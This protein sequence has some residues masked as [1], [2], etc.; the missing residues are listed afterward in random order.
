MGGR[1]RAAATATDTADS[2]PR[3]S[4]ATTR[5]AAVA[6][7]PPLSPSPPS[8]CACCLHPSRLGGFESSHHH[9]TYVFPDR[10]CPSAAHS[11]PSFSTP[12][13]DAIQ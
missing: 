7:P 3:P 6:A 8:D 9:S 10:S 13:P 4:L 2:A 5:V 1:G 12:R 11:K